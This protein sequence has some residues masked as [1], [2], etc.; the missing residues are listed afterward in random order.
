MPHTLKAYH[1]ICEK[2]LVVQQDQFIAE[3]KITLSAFL[4]S[5]EFSVLSL[6]IIAKHFPGLLSFLEKTLP[7][8]PIYY[9]PQKDT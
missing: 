6:F 5:K 8:C 9:V 3:G 2:D 4:H 1:N 7:L